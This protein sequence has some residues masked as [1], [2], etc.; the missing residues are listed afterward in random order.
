M[1]A[2]IPLDKLRYEREYWQQNLMLVAGLD[3]VGRGP[4]AGPVVAAAVILPPEHDIPGVNDSKML[5][6]RQRSL[7]EKAIK[8]QALAWSI[9]MVFPPYLDEINILNATKLAMLDAITLLT[10]QPQ[11]LITDALRLAVNLPQNPVI[12][13]DQKSLS[14]ACASILAKEERDR[15]MVKLAEI[16]PGYGFEHHK[17]YA[18]REHFQALMNLGPCP[19]HRVSFAP[20]REAGGEAYGSSGSLF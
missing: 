15:I 8:D 17:G 5:T 4:L 18:T 10:S 6:P 14:V 3:E 12:K 20:V 13:G 9:G 16:Y 1:S 7:M 19:I 2:D 11:A